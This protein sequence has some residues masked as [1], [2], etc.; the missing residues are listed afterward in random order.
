[1]HIVPMMVFA[2]KLAA[3]SNVI[4]TFVNT[5]DSQARMSK[6]SSLPSNIRFVQISD[7]LPVDYDRS[8]NFDQ[9]T[10]SVDNMGDAL[11]D[12]ITELQKSDTP[13]SCVI[14]DSFLP[15]TFDV[16]RKFHLPWVFFWTQS[17]AAYVFYTHLHQLISNGHFPPKKSDKIEYIAGLPTLQH[18]DLPSFIQT[19]D[20]SDFVLQLIFRQFELVDKADWIV[21]NT[22][23]ELESEAADSM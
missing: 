1:G 14:A 22:I 20:A 2:Q 8:A 11:T 21:G 10:R 9:F 6:A 18:E 7:G 19:G 17:V 23:Y 13:I 16:A 5:H 15:W 4:V 12:L 3:A